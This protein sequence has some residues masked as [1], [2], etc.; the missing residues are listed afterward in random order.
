MI[1]KIVPFN[2]QVVPSPMWYSIRGETI[3]RR[4]LS[5][6]EKM[7]HSDSSNRNEVLED[8]EEEGKDNNLP[9]SL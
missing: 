7:S 2:N 5:E 8:I 9:L 6:E 1:S 3:N 4:S